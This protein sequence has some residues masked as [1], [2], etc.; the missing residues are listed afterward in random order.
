[1]K[2]ISRITDYTNRK[3]FDETVKSSRI[4]RL[5]E[6]KI[7]ISRR[8]YKNNLRGPVCDSYTEYAKR[9]I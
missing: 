9:I 1:M 7:L 6:S 5:S 3:L 4:E 2:T 8:F